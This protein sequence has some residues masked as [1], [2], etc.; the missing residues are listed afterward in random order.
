MTEELEKRITRIE[1][2]IAIG[3]LRARYS[4][5]V[6]G[7]RGREAVDLFTDDG[8]FHGPFT[9]YRGR[10]EQLRHYDEHALAGM[11]HFN[12]NEIVEIDGDTATGR[13]YCQMPCV[14]GGESYVCACEYDDSFVKEAGTWR[15]KRRTVTFHYFVPLKDGW[16]GERIKLPDAF[17]T[18]DAASNRA[19]I[20]AAPRPP[21]ANR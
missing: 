7:G 13:C 1:D 11:W 19:E 8:E 3:E 6:D 10:A 16:A 4:F 20:N 5:L 14:L 17:K 9:S 18:H 15:F 2:R 12:T 21:G